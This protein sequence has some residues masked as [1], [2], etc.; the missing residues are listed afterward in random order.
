MFFVFNKSKIY[1]YVIALCT[2]ILLFVAATKLN[3]IVTPN[4]IE[5]SANIVETQNS[6][7]NNIVTTNMANTIENTNI[8]DKNINTTE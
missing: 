7:T 8:T 2:V 1:S 4:I 6:I 3:D 5:T